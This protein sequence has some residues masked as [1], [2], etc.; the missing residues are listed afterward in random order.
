MRVAFCYFANYCLGMQKSILFLVS[1]LFITHSW[2]QIQVSGGI[3]A[4][5]R[6]ENPKA[7]KGHNNKTQFTNTR[8]SVFLGMATLKGDYKLRE[9]WELVVD[10]SFGQRAKEFQSQELD[11]SVLTAIKQGFIAYSFN[12]ALQVTA[13]SWVSHLGYEMVDAH[14][15]KNYS[16][17]YLFTNSPYIHTGLKVDYKNGKHSYMIGSSL[18]ADRRIALTHDHPF[19]IGQYGYMETKWS[20]LLGYYGG[21]YGYNGIEQL[22]HFDFIYKKS[23]NNRLG[24]GYNGTVRLMQTNTHKIHNWYGNAIYL[25][26]T[27]IKETLSLHTRIEQFQDNDHYIL[28]PN[29]KV[30]QVL[31]FTLSA[32]LKLGQFIIIPEYRVDKADGLGYF[33]DA[34]NNYVKSV[35]SWLIA[36]IYRFGTK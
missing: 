29:D 25:D 16:V 3:D 21:Y 28:T 5:F 10:I 8:D 36:G 17:S 35:Q 1:V 33:S 18:P 2:A 27:F 11:N 20:L 4:Y 23:L 15:N 24:L 32:N 6:K 22:H 14:L 31:A 26:Y 34:S 7:F 9:K 13:G 19:A 12:D 30:K